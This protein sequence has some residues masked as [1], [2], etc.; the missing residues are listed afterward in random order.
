MPSPVHL[1]CAEARSLTEYRPPTLPS[2]GDA[3]V[4]LAGPAGRTP[5]AVASAICAAPWCAVVVLRDGT[6]PGNLLPLLPRTPPVLD[7]NLG[8]SPG[9]IIAALE[10]RPVPG[11]TDLLD[12]LLLRGLAS[13]LVA[14]VHEA[15]SPPRDAAE[16]GSLNRRLADYGPMRARSWR[17]LLQILQFTSRPAEDSGADSR[18]F[19]ARSQD[20]VGLAPRRV[21]ETPGWE[22]KLEATLRRHDYIPWPA[23]TRRSSAAFT[24]PVLHRVTSSA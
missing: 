10:R 20:L 21:L 8:I 9:E 22:W 19:R 17:A 1:F 16:R 2:L 11:A 15:L 24:A 3:L 4:L 13:E 12:Y 5:A 18:T 6:D 14:A 7:G 23:P